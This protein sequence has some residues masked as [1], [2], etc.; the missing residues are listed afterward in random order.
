MMRKLLFL[1]ILFLL[2]FMVACG[3]VAE[4]PKEDITPQEPKLD[5]TVL[6]AVVISESIK[7]DGQGT[8]KIWKDAPV[9]TLKN[10]AELQ[11]SYS[12]EKVY[13]L[14]KWKDET[15][16]LTRGDSWHLVD[17]AWKTTKDMGISAAEDRFNILWNINARDFATQ[18]AIIKCH[19]GD[20]P[21]L[22]LEN[23][24][25]RVDL[26]HGKS[27]RDAGVIASAQSG[28]LAF[29]KEGDVYQVTAGTI[30]LEGYLDDQV[31]FSGQDPELTFSEEDGGRLGDQ[32][33]STYGRN[34]TKDKSGPIYLEK[35]PADYIDAMILT[36]KEIDNGEAIVA[37]VTSPDFAEAE[38]TAAWAKYQALNAIVPE[39]ILRNPEGSRGDVK[40]SSV[41]ANGY[42]TIEMERS[43]VTG[44][45]DDVQFDDLTKEYYFAT[46]IHDN[47]GGIKHN[48]SD[49]LNKM[50]FVK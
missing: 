14:A 49:T 45:S 9:L 34:R 33:K 39:R 7:L 5:S 12:N 50:V 36:Q 3:Q 28:D 6:N 2:V 32:G 38:V 26:W 17:N 42:W 22:Y 18:G 37:D 46:S 16:S 20:E 25:E 47:S 23:A 13:F 21:E 24:G 27:A 19:V 1:S 43:L 41:W 30:N 35:N 11:A 15:M 40:V 31:I 44:N 4:K 10:G 8:E 29:A 48:F